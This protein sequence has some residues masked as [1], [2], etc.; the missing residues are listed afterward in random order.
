M[1]GDGARPLVEGNHS[2]R[3]ALEMLATVAADRE[4]LRLGQLARRLALPK[5]SA[6]SLLRALAVAGFVEGDAR[7]GYVVGLRAFEVGVAYLSRMGP[8]AAARPE[9][10]RLRDTLGVAAHLAIL[11]GSDAV[12][13]A[14][15]GPA[16]SGPRLASSVGSRLPAHLTAVGRAQLAHRPEAVA[17]LAI[18]RGRAR[19]LATELDRARQRGYAVDRGETVAGIGCLASPV[20]DAAGGCAGAVGISFLLDGGPADETAGPLVAAAAR[21]ISA[22]LGGTAPG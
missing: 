4:P 8:V 6:H 1:V 9:L 15:E 18:H 2:V 21:R 12:Y 3:R 16:G 22:R 17:G 5:S 14:A 20:F 11:D 10:A 19:R 13:L 7:S